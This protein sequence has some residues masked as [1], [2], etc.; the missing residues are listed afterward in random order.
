MMCENN[1]AISL[2]KTSTAKN[3]LY[4]KRGEIKV[5]AMD[6]YRH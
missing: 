6:V 5:T 4:D 2:K 3:V 1:L